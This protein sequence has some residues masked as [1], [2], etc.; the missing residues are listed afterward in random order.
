MR[1]KKKSRWLLGDCYVVAK[2]FRLVA[3]WLLTVQ[4]K[5]ALDILVSS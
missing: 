3:R 2:V 4:T 1:K 5:P